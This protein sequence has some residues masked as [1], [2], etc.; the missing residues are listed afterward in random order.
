M[1]KSRFILAFF[2]MIFLYGCSSRLS[3]SEYR[4]SAFSEKPIVVD[5]KIRKVG[6]ERYFTIERSIGERIVSVVSK[7]KRQTAKQ[8]DGRALV[9]PVLPQYVL[10]LTMLEETVIGVFFWTRGSLTISVEG[11]RYELTSEKEGHALKELLESS[12]QTP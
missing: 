4:T 5:Y 3:L 7:A 2:P 11:F 6:E 8:T 1:S 12:T 9:N 10:H